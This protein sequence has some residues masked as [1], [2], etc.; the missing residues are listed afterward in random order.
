MNELQSKLDLS[1]NLRICHFYPFSLNSAQYLG[2]SP[3]LVSVPI[4]A[5][6]FDKTIS[7]HQY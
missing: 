6:I 4:T 1:S 7:F 3:L 2:V 5:L